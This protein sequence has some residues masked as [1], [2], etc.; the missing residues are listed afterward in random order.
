MEYLPYG[1][2]FLKYNGKNTDRV[3]T[4]TNKTCYACYL[5]PSYSLHRNDMF[6]ENIFYKPKITHSLQQT[7]CDQ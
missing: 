6:H 3:L 2:N 1:I 4:Q 7:V 5:S